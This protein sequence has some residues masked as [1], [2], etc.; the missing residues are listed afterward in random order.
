MTRMYAGK[1]YEIPKN[2]NMY[3]K[4]V[5]PIVNKNVGRLADS[6]ILSAFSNDDVFDILLSI[7]HIE[8]SFILS[9]VLR[10]AHCSPPGS[11]QCYCYS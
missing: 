2:R 11:L 7:I 8:I 3:V 6:M 4:Y 10:F 9:H 5:I 1:M